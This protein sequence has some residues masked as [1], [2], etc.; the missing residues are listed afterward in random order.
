MAT[1]K[2]PFKQLFTVKR[3]K[4]VMRPMYTNKKIALFSVAVF[5][6]F[7]VVVTLAANA[8]RISR[9][10]TV[11][12]SNGQEVRLGQDIRV[13]ERTLGDKLYKVNEEQFL[14]R[15]KANDPIE[16]VI[17]VGQNKRVVA[18]HLR[19]P[20]NRVV[21]NNAQVGL[22]LS[23]ASAALEG[24]R[25]VRQQLAEH[26]DRYVLVEQSQSSQFLFSDPCLVDSTDVAAV[27]LV[28]LVRE[29]H[30]DRVERFVSDGCIDH[31]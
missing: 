26:R 19:G 10:D 15:Q 7:G 22:R 24:A 18:V 1:S 13:I 3:F 27:S 2:S 9:E 25:E 6:V 31:D 20:G 14:Y 16:A 28:S 12:L 21:A 29:G 23:Q 8:A 5:A 30:E 4:S 17:E 11:Q